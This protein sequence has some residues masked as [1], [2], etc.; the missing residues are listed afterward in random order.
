VDREIKPK[1]LPSYLM[2]AGPHD[3]I[4]VAQE[5]PAGFALYSEGGGSPDPKAYQNWPDIEKRM[6]ME[7]LIKVGGRKNKAA[8]SLGWGRSTLWRKMK[9]YG[10]R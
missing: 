9:K 2:E 3:G 5:R 7:A 10:I 4:A 8:A 1:H 6:I